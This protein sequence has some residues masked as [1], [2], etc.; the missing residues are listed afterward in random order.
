M[1]SKNTHVVSFVQFM[2][3]NFVIYAFFLRVKFGLKFL[4]RVKDL[5][6]RNS[7]HRWDRDQLPVHQPRLVED[8][9]CRAEEVEL[10]L[11]PA[12]ALAPVEGLPGSQE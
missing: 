7:G 9:V 12:P 10:D 1:S 5:T 11:P 4:L 3:Q 2:Y 8:G 6:F